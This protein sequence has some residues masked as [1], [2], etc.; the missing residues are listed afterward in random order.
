M[1]VGYV[2]AQFDGI[3]SNGRGF[4]RPVLRTVVLA[5]SE[6]RSVRKNGATDSNRARNF[7]ILFAPRD[8]KP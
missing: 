8:R 4:C 7:G 2:Q 5:T 3:E 1:N 6:G